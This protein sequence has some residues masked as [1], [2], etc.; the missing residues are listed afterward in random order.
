MAAEDYLPH[1]LHSDDAW[2]FAGLPDMPSTYDQRYNGSGVANHGKPWTPDQDTRLRKLVRLGETNGTIAHRI[3]RTEYAIECRI[4]ALGLE[5]VP[6]P[7]KSKELNVKA[8][9]LL[10]LLQEGY[11]T[12][13]VVY[14]K[15]DARSYT[16]KASTA[17]NLQPGDRVV[18]PANEE[19]KVAHVTAVHAEPQIDFTA[20]YALKWVVQRVD[21]TEYD[22]QCAAEAAALAELTRAQ[23]R[24][25]QEEALRTLFGDGMGKLAE[26]KA[27]LNGGGK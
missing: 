8:V 13:S 12:I 1:G 9:H 17:M 25:A 6:Q 27:L 22:R 19:M 20:P 5:A 4:K 11:T 2:D 24:R 18:V 23:Q 21:M 3:G 14:S 10:T 7:I 15:A 16:Y 26:I